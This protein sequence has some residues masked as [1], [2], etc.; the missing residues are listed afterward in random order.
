MIR[1]HP[2][3]DETS[4]SVPTPDK[5]APKNCETT[6]NLKFGKIWNF[7]LALVCQILSQNGQIWAFWVKKY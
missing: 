3:R 7:L 5:T 2:K 4:R 6:Q 1:D